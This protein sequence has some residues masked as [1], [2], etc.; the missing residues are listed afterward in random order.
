V[1]DNSFQSNGLK[2]IGG[3]MQSR[4]GEERRPINDNMNPANPD[5]T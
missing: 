1:K 2:L 4:P 3:D 5:L